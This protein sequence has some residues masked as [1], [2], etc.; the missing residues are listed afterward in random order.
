MEVIS[1]PSLLQITRDDLLSKYAH[2]LLFSMNELI[3]THTHTHTH[4]PPS[5]SEAKANS[6][7]N[8]LR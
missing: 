5:G 1:N 7:D 4:T 2:L 6:D 3:Y 8:W